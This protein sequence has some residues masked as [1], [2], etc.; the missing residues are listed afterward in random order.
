MSLF[1]DL[2]A[3][4][5]AAVK[6]VF[7]EPALL[8]PR[9]STQYAERSADPD[10]PEAMT[11]GIFSA[12]PAQEDLR[13]QARGGQ[14]S[15]TTKLSTAAAEFWIAKPQIDQLPWLPITGDAVILTA[16]SGQPIYAISRVA[17]SDLGDL[18]LMLVRED[19]TP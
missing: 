12:G 13:G 1:N 8:R 10:R 19:E 17:T 4:T 16:R 14:M 11:Y 7:A 5:S 6:A 3:H 2:D 18:N 15:G 9:M